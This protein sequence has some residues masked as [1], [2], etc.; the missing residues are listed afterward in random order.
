MLRVDCGRWDQTPETLRE[1][2]TSASHPRTRERCLALYEITQDSN[3]TAVAERSGR[4]P[5]TLMRWVHRY[6]ERGP[7]TLIYR[8]S[9]GRP[10]FASGSNSAS[11]E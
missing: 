8:H 3:A 5:Q 11:M 9:G 4:N 10:L 7:E 1:W 6:N 2:A